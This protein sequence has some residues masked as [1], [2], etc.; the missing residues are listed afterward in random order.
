MQYSYGLWWFLTHCNR[1]VLVWLA[2]INLLVTLISLGSAINKE[3]KAFGDIILTVEYIIPGRH[4]DISWSLKLK[5]WHI[6]LW[7]G[8]LL[9]AWPTFLYSSFIRQFEL[10][11][12]S[13]CL[14][15]FLLFPF[16]VQGI[17]ILL[18]YTGKK[19]T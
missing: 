12:T 10:R 5:K 9:H 16:F 15:Y 7:K 8:N 3:C 2:L 6:Y 14:I 19:L 13:I 4:S 1:K 17:N 18:K 11:K